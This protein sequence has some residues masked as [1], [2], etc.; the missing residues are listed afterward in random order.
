[1]L[2]L[3]PLHIEFSF[4]MLVVRGTFSTSVHLIKLRPLGTAPDYRGQ[5]SA[6]RRT[7]VLPGESGNLLAMIFTESNSEWL[8][9]GIG[10]VPYKGKCQ[11]D[12]LQSAWH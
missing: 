3:F 7:N 1:M 9:D 12:F 10:S 5:K 11:A 4:P 2:F 8:S 6:T